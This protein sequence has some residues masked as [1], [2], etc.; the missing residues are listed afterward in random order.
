MGSWRYNFIYIIRKVKPKMNLY[1]RIVLIL[2]AIALIYL[3]LSVP[4]YIPVEVRTI[5][6]N[7]FNSLSLFLNS[8]VRAIIVIGCTL[9]VFFALKGIDKKKYE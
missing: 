7:F 1:Q 5:F 6:D 3:F 2:G 8:I 4:K 9:L